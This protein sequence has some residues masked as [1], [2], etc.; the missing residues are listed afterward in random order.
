MPSIQPRIVR[1]SVARSPDF[2]EQP[3]LGRR[4][5][6]CGQPQR[7]N[8]VILFGG[9]IYEASSKFLPAS[10]WLG[11]PHRHQALHQLARSPTHWQ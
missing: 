11:L 7:N 1:M 4:L 8:Y 5:G 2:H 10:Q 9:R 6:V 3:R